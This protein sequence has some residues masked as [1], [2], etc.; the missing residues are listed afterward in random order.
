LNQIFILSNE[1]SFALTCKKVYEASQKM[2]LPQKVEFLE[3]RVGLVEL[4]GCA[5]VCV[6]PGNPFMACGPN[7]PLVK[8]PLYG[9]PTTEDLYDYEEEEYGAFD[10]NILFGNVQEMHGRALTIALRH[11]I[12]TKEVVMELHKRMEE[13]KMEEKLVRMLV[14][15][16][17]QTATPHAETLSAA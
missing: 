8:P 3:G 1:S 15:V 4:R 7:G 12:C 17:A 10:D 2:T 14:K 13:M 16:R 5:P 6:V 11:G 9:F